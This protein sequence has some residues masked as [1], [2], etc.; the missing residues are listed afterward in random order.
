MKK[1]KVRDR[2]A[3]LIL[4]LVLI[5]GLALFLFRVLPN[6][7]NAR[8]QSQAAIRYAERVAAMDDDDYQAALDAA[9]DYNAALYTTDLL[10]T[11]TDAQ[12]DGY[13]AALDVDGL[14]CMAVID[15]PALGVT[16]P[17][18]H[19]GVEAAEQAY[20]T[21]MEGT[22]LPVGVRYV[23]LDDSLRAPEFGA[24][25]ILS[26]HRS[27]LS[28]RLFNHLDRLAEGD[29]FTLRVLDE[30]LTYEVDDVSVIEPGTLYAQTIGPGRDDVILM[31]DTPRGTGNHL[32]L[33]RGRRVE[34]GTPVSARVPGDGVRISRE[35]V[36]PFVA[37][38][39]LAVL[40]IWILIALSGAAL[41]RRSRG[42]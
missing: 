19:G 23:E 12:R 32:L 37:V 38:P 21:H 36:A 8:T 29:R 3:T 14:G 9:L 4:L 20:V 17:V 25:C 33:V 27:L 5:G 42:Q 10:W 15:I 11:M 2:L 26:D 39:A 1:R 30:T 41:R 22:S 40:L 16:L 18:Y 31:T 24:S 13:A 6:Y 35:L 28:T 7:L 34:N